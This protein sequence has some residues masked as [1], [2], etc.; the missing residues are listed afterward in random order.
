MSPQYHSASCSEYMG[1]ARQLLF[2]V[3]DAGFV[4]LGGRA[5]QQTRKRDKIRKCKRP[6]RKFL[7]KRSVWDC[8]VLICFDIKRST[9]DTAL[10]IL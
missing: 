8:D 10:S 7:R 4:D 1:G 6:G 9:V 2:M 3:E 5:R